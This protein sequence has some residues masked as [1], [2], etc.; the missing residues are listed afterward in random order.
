MVRRDRV[1]DVL[2][3]HGLAGTRRRHDQRALTL[4]DRRDDV[5]DARRQI[6]LGRILVLHL[7]P[8]VRIERRQ[9]VEVDLVARL[10]GLLEVDRV[11]LEQ[12]EITFA[13]L[14]RADVAVDGIAGAQAKTANLRG[15]DVNVVRAGEVIRFR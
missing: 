1:G 13:F 7:E 8:F 14:R 10:L 3:Q 9:V 11:D 15:R 4:A 2:Q 12:R 5:D 6:L